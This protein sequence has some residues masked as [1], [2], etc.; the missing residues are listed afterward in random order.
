LSALSPLAGLRIGAVSYLNTKPLIWP[1]P[2]GGVTLDVPARLADSFYQGN[3]DVA[4]LP[5][6][7]V[8]HHGGGSVVDDVAIACEGAVYSVLVG[9]RTAFSECG[10]IYLDPSSR[11]SVA[12]LRV[13]IGEFYPHLSVRDGAPPEGASRLLIGD[14]AITFHRQLRDGWQCHDLGM[15]WREH[16]GLPFVFAAWALKKSLPNVSGV[17]GALRES[18]RSGLE[19]REQIALGEQDPDFARRYLTQFIRYD[20]GAR[21]RESIGLFARLAVKHGL[22]TEEPSLHFV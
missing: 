16:T 5:M 20:I 2:A 19:A 3:L 14:P 10:E 12:L 17:A 1:L 22:L 11:S 21:E 9:S 6:F 18:K 4:L 13:L 8:L 15:L 7:E